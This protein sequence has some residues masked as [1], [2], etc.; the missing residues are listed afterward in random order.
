MT[1]I[2]ILG[3]ASGVGKSTFGTRFLRSEGWEHLELDEYSGGRVDSRL[4]PGWEGFLCR[5][6]P[7]M[8]KDELSRRYGDSANVVLTTTGLTLFDPDHIA[9]ANGHFHIAYLWGVPEACLSSFLDR[10]RRRNPRLTGL[11][12][13]LNNHRVY[14]WLDLP[15]NAPLRVNA[16]TENGERRP[17]EDVLADLERLMA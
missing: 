6:N 16:F 15:F 11:H 14:F 3:G 5:Y 9:A 1:R 7:V 12:W 17:D 4:K 2:L 8:L 10:D 13:L